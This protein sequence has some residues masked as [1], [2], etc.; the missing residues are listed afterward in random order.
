MRTRRVK[1]RFLKIGQVK[2]L[3]DFFSTTQKTN[4]D[5]LGTDNSPNQKRNAGVKYLEHFAV[6]LGFIKMER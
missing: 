6:L 4:G 1:K 3:A 5:P 2:S